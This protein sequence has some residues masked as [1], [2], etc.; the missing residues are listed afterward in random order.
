MKQFLTLLICLITLCSCHKKTSDTHSQDNRPEVKIGV[1]APLSGGLAFVGESIVAAG[2]VAEDQFPKDSKFKYTFIYED[3]QMDPKKSI[4]AA[5]KLM[6]SDKVDLLITIWSIAGIPVDPIAEK[7]KINHICMG[8]PTKSLRNQGQYNFQAYSDHLEM[9]KSNLA[10]LQKN[11]VKRMAFIWPTVAEAYKEM[12]DLLTQLA[13]QYG[14]EIVL[15]ESY[16]PDEKTFATIITK[17]KDANPDI[18]WSQTF[19]PDMERIGEAAKKQNLTTPFT[20]VETLDE[21]EKL[22]NF[23]GAIYEA[24]SWLDEGFLAKYNAKTNVPLTNCSP[25]YYYVAL[26][27]KDAYEKAPGTTKPTSEEFNKILQTASIKLKDDTVI[28]KSSDNCFIFPGATKTIKAGKPTVLPS[29]K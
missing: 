17:V 15:N 5:N 12:S 22:A 16:N 26:M 18:I 28:T 10:R 20:C 19:G 9:A 11:G 21:T 6:N 13:P 24:A 4:L 8:F 1:I 25:F 27:I 14:I 2:K 29:S 23:E 7:A 3:S